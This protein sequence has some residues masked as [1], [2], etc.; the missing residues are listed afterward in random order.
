MNGRNDTVIS[1]AHKDIE[2]TRKALE[3]NGLKCIQLDL[4]FAFH[5]AQMDP[6]LESFEQTAKH[7]TFKAPSVPLISPLLSNCVFDG[8]TINAKYFCRAARE[9]VNFVGALEAAQDLG[10]IDDKTIWID[11]GPHPVCGAFVRSYIASATV[12]SSLR[13]NEDNFAVIANSL[14]TLHCEGVSVCW[15]EYFKPYE[16]RTIC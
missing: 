5:T 10:I 15:N 11:I 14:A 3:S 13:R 1:G 8:K 2:A 16:R 9:S 7:V 12:V 6:I 4:P